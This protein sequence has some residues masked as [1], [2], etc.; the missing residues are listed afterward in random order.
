MD[1]NPPEVPKTHSIPPI[2]TIN[3]DGNIGVAKNHIAFEQLPIF[4]KVLRNFEG[5]NIKEIN[6][7]SNLGGFFQ[8]VS[9]LSEEVA[10]DNPSFIRDR[11]SDLVSRVFSARVF[12]DSEYQ[13][14]IGYTKDEDRHL[15][16]Q[17]FFKLNNLLGDSQKHTTPEERRLFY[18]IFLEYLQGKRGVLE[19]ISD[20]DFY[21]DLR[22][23][24]SQI[25]ELLKQGKI[26]SRFI[27]VLNYAL[28]AYK[29]WVEQRF[30]LPKEQKEKNLLRK[31]H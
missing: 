3:K 13:K 10:E 30:N 24:K 6:S 17:L 9:L 7:Q 19:G 15:F 27:I 29:D 26:D 2:I 14:I 4:E 16:A 22:N 28:L 8:I 11:W 21:D 1:S 5:I 20:K 18:E 25:F 12:S 31:A 23:N